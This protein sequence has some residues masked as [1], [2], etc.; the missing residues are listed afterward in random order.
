MGDKRCIDS[1]FFFYFIFLN[2][3]IQLVAKKIISDDF[4]IRLT[5]SETI[6][7][8]CEEFDLFFFKKS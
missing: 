8:D 6:R 7:N 1:T 4:D 5:A 3:L 2:I